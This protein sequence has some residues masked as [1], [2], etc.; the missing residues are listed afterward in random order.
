MQVIKGKATDSAADAGG[1]GGGRGR[2]AALFFR[3]CN[4]PPSVS[5]VRH[6]PEATRVIAIGGETGLGLCSMRTAAVQGLLRALK[7]EKINRRQ[8]KELQQL[9]WWLRS[10]HKTA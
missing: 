6:S 9:C 3:T 10:T 5:V 1:G 4:R 8:K 7:K 2:A